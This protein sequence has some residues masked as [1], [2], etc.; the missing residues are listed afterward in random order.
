[1]AKAIVVAAPSSGSGKTLV[2]LGLVRALNEAGIRTASA[3]VGPDYIDP[4]FHELASRRP[5][6]NLDLWSMG[7]D[8]CHA[9]LAAQAKDADIVIVEGVMGLFDGPEGSTGSTADLAASLA[10]PVILVVDASH[11]SQSIAALVHGFR[12]FRTDVQIAGII[13]NRVASPRHEVLLRAALAEQPIPV[14]GCVYRHADMQW[15]SRHLGLVQAIEHP[16]TDQF[17]AEA[18]R[19]ITC[20]VAIHDIAA[21]ARAVD[22]TATAMSLPPLGQRIAVAHDAAFSFL[23]PHL[24]EGWRIAGTEITFFSPLAD[25]AVPATADAVYLPGGYPELHA[26]KLSQ[27][28]HFLPSLKQ[29]AALIYGECGG[30]MVLG[31]M[32]VDADGTAH[33]MAGLLPHATSFQHKKLHLGYRRLVPQG[34]PWTGPLRGHEF[35]YSTFITKG[36]GEPL[37]KAQD[38]AGRDLGP[39]GLRRGKVM[40]S[41]A[42][43]IAAESVA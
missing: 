9:I 17:I 36:D 7:A 27:S 19:H 6:P 31:E 2:T 23:Y 38:A 32:L 33:A 37:F 41:Y 1:M 10:L 25:E 39:L 24:L 5:C 12:T 3:K 30:F 43:V 8:Q 40:G 29:S 15:P 26:G 42:H 22:E 35:H 4:R 14:L 16:S 28:K 21:L 13:L 18:A 34:G 11:Q 20:E